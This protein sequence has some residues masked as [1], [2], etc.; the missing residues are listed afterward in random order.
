MLTWLAHALCL[1][2]LSARI[3]TND[4]Y[5]FNSFGGNAEALIASELNNSQEPDNL[6]PALKGNTFL[7]PIPNDL[8]FNMPRLI[9]HTTKTPS[10]H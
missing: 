8:I 2:V 5:N 6:G 4:Q 9:V 7:N 3:M 10:S 1:C